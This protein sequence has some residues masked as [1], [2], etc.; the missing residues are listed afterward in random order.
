MLSIKKP[1]NFNHLT[2]CDLSSAGGEFY[3][4]S[5][6]CQQPFSPLSIF[7]SKPF[8]ITLEPLTL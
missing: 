4:V 6:R 5:N 3:S 7:R 2:R 8:R 1:F